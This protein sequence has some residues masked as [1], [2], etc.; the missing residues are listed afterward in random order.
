M[1]RSVDTTKRRGHVKSTIAVDMGVRY[2]CA[3]TNMSISPY[4]RDIVLAC[5]KGLA[6]VD[7]EFPL[8]PPRTLRLD[9]MWKIAAVAWSPSI[10]YHGWVATTVNQALAIHDLAHTTG[11]PM[12]VLKAHP[13][14]I[15]DV[16]WAPLTQAWI[17]TASIDPVVKIWDVRRDQKPVWYY[18]EW[19][20]ADK[21]AFNNVNMFKM[22]TVHR[23]KIAVWDIRKGSSPLLTVPDAHGDD[24]TSISWHPTLKNV[25]VSA[26]LDSTVKRWSI[27]HGYP[28]EEYCHR[29]QHEVLSAKYLPFGEG[30]LVTQR[31]PDNRAMII[32]DSA[33]V[34]V[35]HQFIGHEG[36]ILGS[37]WRS[38][39][40]ADS[41]MFQ[42]VTWGQDQTLRLWTAGGLLMERVG[43]AVHRKQEF[44]YV[45][46]PSFAAN[47]LRPNDVMH[48][49]AKKLLP[50]EL[51]LAATNS[52]GARRITTMHEFDQVGNM[53][54]GI[55]LVGGGDRVAV[56]PTVSTMSGARTGTPEDHSSDDD[57]EE[58]ELHGEGE[59]P[60]TAWLREVEAVVGGTYKESKTVTVKSLSRDDRQCWLVVGVP[61]ITRE[62]V[63]L[64]AT[65]PG[66]YPSAALEFA[67]ET[68]GPEFGAGTEE[69]L[70]RVVGVADA[71]AVQGVKALHQCLYS[72][73]S[74]LITYGR[75]KAGTAAKQRD[76]GRL[77]PAPPALLWEAVSGVVARSKQGLA[78]KGKTEAVSDRSRSRSTGKRGSE[79]AVAMSLTSEDMSL[80][81]RDEEEPNYSDAMSELD[82]DDDEDDD[83]EEEDY[84]GFGFDDGYGLYQSDNSQSEALAG[85]DGPSYRHGSNRDRYDAHTPFPRL[86]GGVFS[87]PGQ[88][89]CFFASM[90]TP[91]TYPGQGAQG[92]RATCR[93]E[94]SQQLRAQAKPRNLARLGNYQNMVQL[95]LHSSGVFFAYH[96]ARGARE[97]FD[98]DDS[99]ARDEEAPRFY[100]RQQPA[101]RGSTASPAPS[102]TSARRA[103]SPARGCGVGNVAVVCRVAQD[104]TADAG[105]A[106]ALVLAGI[107]A[108]AV[109]RHNARAA[110]DSGRPALA[111]TWR[112]LACLMSALEGARLWTA[113]APVVRWL[114]AVLAHYEAAGDVQTLALVACV[115]SLAAAPVRT[116]AP[117]MAAVA[118]TVLDGLARAPAPA[119]APDAPDA[120][121]HRIIDDA[122]ERARGGV[123]VDATLGRRLADDVTSE[124]L[125]RTM[126]F[127]AAYPYC[128]VS[129]TPPLLKGTRFAP[130]LKSPEILHELDSDEIKQNELM[131]NEG[132]DEPPA[133][134]SR[135]GLLQRTASEL[136]LA[137]AEVE[138]PAQRRNSSEQPPDRPS[139]PDGSDNLWHRLRTN[140]LGRVQTVG[141]YAQ[142]G[143]PDAMPAPPDNDQPAAMGDWKR[144]AESASPSISD[145]PLGNGLPWGDRESAHRAKD[146]EQTYLRVRRE[147]SASRTRLVVHKKAEEDVGGGDY[148]SLAPY[149][150]HWKLI[151]SRI[152]YKWEM[153]AKA[154]EVLKCI[155][156][157]NIRHLYNQLQ[158]QPT[159][160]QHDNLPRDGI[161]SYRPDPP[162]A[163]DSAEA[164]CLASAE[165]PGAPWLSCS[166]CHEY[167]HGRALICHA[168]GHGGHQEHIIR[169]FRTARKQ[170]KRIGLAPVNYSRFGSS[171][172]SSSS[173]LGLLGKGSS[174]LTN[175]YSP[176]LP[177]DPTLAVPEFGGAVE[178]DRALLLDMLPST[179]PLSRRASKGSVFSPA[180]SDSSGDESTPGDRAL[181]DS[182]EWDSSDADSDDHLQTHRA[183]VESRPRRLGRPLEPT[184]LDE[185]FALQLEIPTCPTG[186]GCSC[187]YESRRLIM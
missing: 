147:Y 4:G 80:L 116:S 162:P 77:P 175:I 47:F 119:A 13:K 92:R 9:S 35:E 17:G 82:E 70:G 140:V 118:Q 2:P 46:A 48:L 62:T 176:E 87:G 130:G 111:H 133:F 187:I 141:G 68:P 172:S 113:H 99:D 52:T 41:S 136:R 124:D 182:R 181:P 170:L 18:T 28:T 139:P 144:G 103:A 163:V 134:L 97:A 59:D 31:S 33:V 166:W 75:G 54:E 153:D 138:A 21:L 11:Q 58:D 22:A 125:Q 145:Y 123:A 85:M 128:S 143:K 131:M 101:S 127:V 177:P 45:E 168:C 89:V 161:M 55:G 157:P 88:L 3:F 40:E 126:V 107:S 66:E 25:L 160:P 60:A 65:F 26:S 71:C 56:A 83:S 76:I 112:L 135:A 38:L 27:D 183:G 10:A 24:I 169:W 20:P 110:A 90:Y 186:C 95:G 30:L 152:L 12:R 151:Y 164:P 114:R 156:D 146:I 178:D 159:V 8:N 19:E 14:A 34:S 155:Q 64:H 36:T 16:S 179:E 129:K 23:N 86:C 15:T 53:L 121:I 63:H 142:T 171:N 150:D 106:R 73:L 78:R 67:L 72:L 37:E 185:A 149:L 100:F 105:L 94:M 104:A 42:L 32:R 174:A 180:S 117:V 102:D 115:L 50:S 29:F 173:N 132:I 96:S 120:H 98:S 49:V 44:S 184:Q 79:H 122:L 137:R 167:V 74:L 43:G 61:W 93:E 6:I 51:L 148:R 158:C 69:L 57:D 165:A 39:N 1:S 5:Q 84:D 154:V 7:L 108:D 109:C 91:D 81:A